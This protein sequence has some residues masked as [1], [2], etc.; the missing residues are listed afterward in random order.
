[1]KTWLL[2]WNVDRWFWDD[3]LN[4]Y[5]ELICDIEQEGHT[6]CKWTCGN[7]KSIKKGDRIFLIKLGA[8][9]RGIVA[10]GF[11]ATDVFEGTHW[12]TEKRKE[13]KKARRIFVDFDKIKDYEI[14]NI[15]EYE[16]LTTISKCFQWSTQSSGIQIPE[17]IAKQIEKYWK[18]V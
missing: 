13:G 12:D 2:T 17:N 9:P 4:G 16:Q 15:L 8:L 18:S 14:D 5:K 1:M 3:T 6:F 7:N 10:S 11:A